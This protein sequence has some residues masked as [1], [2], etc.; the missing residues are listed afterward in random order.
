M[1][2]KFG[3][4]SMIMLASTLLAGAAPAMN[5]LAAI[6]YHIDSS[7][8]MYQ[9]YGLSNNASAL[10]DECCQGIYANLASWKNRLQD[11]PDNETL[12]NRLWNGVM[13]N[14]MGGIYSG[15]IKLENGSIICTQN[16]WVLGTYDAPEADAVSDKISAIGKAA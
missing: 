15:H 7:K 5:A 3:K 16:S 12:L 9:Y 6:N 8:T 14:L 13:S 10:G 2:R 4:M 11:Y 1:K